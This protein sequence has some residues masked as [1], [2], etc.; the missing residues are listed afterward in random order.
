MKL[1]NLT[2]SA[3]ALILM[4]ACTDATGGTGVEPDDLAGTWTSTSFVLTSVATPTVSL[5]LVA[6]DG[7]VV[8]LVLGTDGT[9]TFT[10]VSN[11]EDTENET[12][13]YTVVGNT[14]STTPTG[15]GGP[16]TMAISRNGD[17]MTLTMDDD[18][19]FDDNGTFD[20]AVL[21]IVLTR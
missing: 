13:T 1:R 10:F 19:D 6:V 9:Y 3:V 17:T 18:F 12:G 5:D 2:I 14:L 20:A 8:T 4:A 16:E 7:A 11:V 15:T 21:V